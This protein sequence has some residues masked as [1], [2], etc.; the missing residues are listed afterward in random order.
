MKSWTKKK[1]MMVVLGIIGALFITELTLRIIGRIYLSKLYVTFEGAFVNN[2]E[3]I[4]VVCLGESST[5]GIWVDP[6]DAYPGQLAK[7]LREHYQNENI[8]VLVPPHIGQNTSQILNRIQHYIDLY[9]PRL[10][11]L[12]L[13]YNNGWSLAESNIGKFLKPN[14]LEAVK[15]EFFVFLDKF[16]VFKV[17]RHFYLKTFAVLED[18][19][20]FKRNEYYLYGHPELV[21]DPPSWVNNFMERNQ[22]ILIELWRYDLK[23]IILEA[24]KSGVP[25]LLMTYHITPS[26]LPIDE[27]VNMAMEQEVILVRND[28]SFL[29]YIKE[30]TINNL[31]LHDHWHP[32]KKGYEIIA[33]NV[34]E[35]ITTTNL[36]GQ[37]AD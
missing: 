5:V 17:L 8:N 19:E 29:P 12:M 33:N 9:Q 24:K 15:I 22:D 30:G 21:Y 7:K 37:S 13:G 18:K 36:L 31:L 1:I 23:K 10:L 34:F 28:V 32:N 3:A 4:N 2:P 20:F 14:S 35:K 27:F 16:R 6:E 25:V 26:R 11:V